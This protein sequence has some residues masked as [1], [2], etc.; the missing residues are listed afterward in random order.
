MSKAGVQ[1]PI[2]NCLPIS[3]GSLREDFTKPPGFRSAR[4][5][6][7]CYEGK[8]KYPGGPD[9]RTS[10]TTAFGVH[11]ASLQRS[12]DLSHLKTRP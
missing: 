4:F 12:E 1:E 8:R 3:R 7:H 5:K 6:N 2:G 11:R 10:T 9:S